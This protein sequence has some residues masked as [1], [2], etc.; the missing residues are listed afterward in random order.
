MARAISWVGRAWLNNGNGTLRDSG[1]RLGSNC[2]WDVAVGDFNADGKPDAFLVGCLWG[3]GLSPAP[4]QV[5]L[6]NTPMLPAR[7]SETHG[8]ALSENPPSAGTH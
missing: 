3:N 8:N 2:M 1:V 4:A 6:N 7:S 5:W